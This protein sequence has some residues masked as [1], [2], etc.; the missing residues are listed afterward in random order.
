MSAYA[1]R[2]GRVVAMDPAVGEPDVLVVDADRIVAVGGDGLLARWP[3]A[4][5]VDLAG[6]AL[7]PGLIDAHNHV[8]IAA[9][10]PRWADAS[11]IGGVDGLATVLREQAQREPD[12]EWIRAAGWEKFGDWPDPL[13]RDALDALGLDRPIIVGHFSIHQGLVCSR[14]LD[15]LGIGR[16][17]PDPH[18]GE[19]LRD[20]DGEPTG[21]LRETAWSSAHARSLVGYTDPDRWGE[22]IAA[23]LRALH[24]EGVTCVHDAACSAAAE[25][26][27]ARLAARQELPSSVLVMP[28]PAELFGGLDATRLDGP[29]T[30]EGDEWLRVGPVKLFADGGTEPLIDA[31][32]DGDRFRSGNPFPPICG[33]VAAATERGFRVAVHAIGNAGLQRAMD[34]FAAVAGRRPDDEHRFRVEHACLASPQQAA[35]LGALGAVAVVQP[36]F[37]ELLGLRIGHLRFADAAWM[38]FGDLADAGVPLAAS[39]DDPCAPCRPLADSRLGVT[40]TLSSGTVLGADQRLGYLDWLRAWTVGAAH[41]GGQERERGSLTPGKRADLVLIDGPLDGSGTPRVT[42]TWVAGRRVY[43]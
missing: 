17:T 3:H 39:S 40:R 35:A 10:E 25:A 38:P 11:G 24:A 13:T 34:A 12:A 28:H 21:L 9:L 42:E 14:G 20:P 7:L 16:N 31:R 6:R 30:G 36:S 26:V 1:F 18:G 33:D 22:N 15:R 19:I 32:L 8:S 2:G 37:V 29:S 5:V 23:R 4:T 41:A 43:P 27:Y